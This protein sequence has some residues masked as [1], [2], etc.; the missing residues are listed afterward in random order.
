MSSIELT[1]VQALPTPV[2]LIR[3]FALDTPVPGDIS[4]GDGFPLSGWAVGQSSPIASILVTE[5][6]QPVTE[7]AIDTRREDVHAVHLAAPGALQSGFQGWV[8]TVG[9]GPTFQ[10]ELHARTAAGDHAALA[11]IS[12]QRLRSAGARAPDGPGRSPA[13]ALPEFFIIGA[14]RGGTRTLYTYL[15]AHPD[16]QRAATDEVHFFSL[17]FDRG[18]SWFLNQFPA[19]EPGRIT[20]EASPYYLFH[21][22]APQRMRAIVPEARLIVLLR[23]PV[24]RAFSQY[25]LEAR[26]GNEPLSFEEALAAEEERLAGEEERLQADDT[27]R[28]F[29]HQ[30]F[31]YQARGH[32]V[33]QLRRWLDRFP[34]EQ[35]LFVKSEDFFADPALAYRR[36]T[37]FLG[38][39]PA[40][41]S[42]PRADPPP[43]RR[44]MRLETRDAL[45]SRF[46]REQPAL[47]RLVGDAFTWEE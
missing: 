9:L 3:G 17:Y 8:P 30:H 40:P 45:Q 1:R 35:L 23:N 41:F 22:L 18:V 26:Q 19:P 21:P 20:G 32:Y 36:A 46:A 14:Q 38:L 28:S 25:Q 13:R 42:L 34:A 4:P 12:G 33:E 7:L 2:Q 11:T 24:D 15:A 29:A 43:G 37:D 44:E 39:R 16:V 10:V 27:Y 5:A 47:R 6:G 31:S